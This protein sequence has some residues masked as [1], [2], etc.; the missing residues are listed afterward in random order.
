MQAFRPG[1]VDLPADQSHTATVD[2]LTLPDMLTEMDLLAPLPDPAELFGAIGSTPEAQDHTL[3]DWGTQ[4]L[5][6]DSINGPASE[7]LV[8]EDE[9]LELDLGDTLPSIEI[10]RRA[11]ESEILEDRPDETLKLYDDEL[12]LDLG[13]DTIIQDAPPIPE[14]RMDVDIE[15]NDASAVDIREETGTREP[16]SPLS[17]VRPSEEPTAE[18]AAGNTSIFEPQ[19]DT[20]VEAP[21]RVKRR[22]VLQEDKDT[23]MHSADIRAL[24]A[25]RS[26]IL[27]PQS[28]LPRDPVL[29]ALMNMQ[30]NGSFVTDILGNGRATNWAPQLKDILSI[31]VICRSGDLKRKRD[32]GVADL[33]SDEDDAHASKS[34]PQLEFEQEDG[35]SFSHHD[36]DITLRSETGIAEALPSSLDAR[37]TSMMDGGDLEP[38]TVLEEGLSP[39][40]AFDDT[41]MPLLHPADA[42]PISQ[43]TK[44]AVHLLREH[45]GADAAD[46]A[47]QRQKTS[48]LFQ[49]LLPEEATSRKEATQMF[50]E[51]LVLATKDAIKVEQSHKDLGGSIRLRAKRGLWGAWAEEKAGGEIATVDGT[52]S[53]EGQ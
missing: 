24:Q 12:P 25:D 41:T 36:A 18:T 33:Y 8:L 34:A 50:F 13:D 29:L 23:E 35:M 51:V 46:A 26:K 4:S 21:Q 14:D 44:R 9:P 6:T 20:I 48:V 32:S 43:G 37:A 22:R 15:G 39:P 38:G 28:F 31:E 2:A 17:D 5:I 3:L 47:E 40:P 45:F 19:D 27:K 11:R 52:G 53:G 42:G 1:N 49:D 16:R 7:A 10:G 30:K